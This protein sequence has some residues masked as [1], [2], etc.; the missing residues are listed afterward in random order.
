MF[1]FSSVSHSYDRI[2]ADAKG[3]CAIFLPDTIAEF[4]DTFFTCRPVSPYLPA[5]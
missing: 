1:I 4:S 5:A 3:L 2:G